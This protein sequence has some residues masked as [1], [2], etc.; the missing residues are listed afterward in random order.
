MVIGLFI[1]LIVIQFFRPEKNVSNDNTY[2]IAKK[3]TIPSEV[4]HILKVA[5][6]DCH[7]NKTE[8]PW[9]AEVQ[10]VAWWLDHHVADGKKHLNFSEFTKR[11]IGIQNHKFEEI[12][13]MVE[14]GEMPLPSY[15]NLGLHKEANLT[16][17]QK[18]ML[19]DWAKQQMETLK[20]TYPADSLVLRRR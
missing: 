10:P 3:Y 16:A 9:Y 15:T 19:L 18:N 1:A 6:N 5:C 17:A 8:Y 12:I 13:E 2:A 11:R 7:S 14:E 4:N 20:N